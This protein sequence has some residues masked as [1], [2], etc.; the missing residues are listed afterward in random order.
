MKIP[1]F[2]ALSLLVGLVVSTA[3]VSVVEALSSPRVSWKVSSLLPGERINLSKVMSTNSPGLKRWSKAGSCRLQPQNKPTKLVMGTSGSCR[4]TVRIAKSRNFSARAS[5]RTISFTQIPSTVALAPALYSVGQI[6]PAGGKIF[7]VDMSRPIGSQYFEVAC[8]GWSDG[9]CGGND[10]TDPT[11]RWGC[12]YQVINGA[13]G[14]AI[15]SGKQNTIDTVAG[16]GTAGIAVRLADALVLG[17][18]SDWFLPSNDELNQIFINRAMLT[19]FA[20]HRYWSSSEANVG[21]AWAKNFING[22]QEPMDRS[23]ELAAYVRPVRSF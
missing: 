2:I 1:R 6:G 21:G 13:D 22:L 8:P 12:G 14:M 9:I 18:Q 20:A 16:C 17:G 5:T 19:G 11:A 15:G 3:S 7:F 23:F 4:L 10:L